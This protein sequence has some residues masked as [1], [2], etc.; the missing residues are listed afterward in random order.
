MKIKQKSPLS[1]LYG[2][3]GT[4][5]GMAA[6]DL[7]CY[8]L[9]GADQGVIALV[10]SMLYLYLTLMQVLICP[11]CLI[12]AI[13]LWIRRLVVNK[14][15]DVHCFVT[16]GLLIFTLFWAIIKIVFLIGEF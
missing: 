2:F 3:C 14:K 10:F 8:G 16:L 15:T 13:V 5:A 1:A 7:I 9:G 12:C 4:L 11:I 6:L